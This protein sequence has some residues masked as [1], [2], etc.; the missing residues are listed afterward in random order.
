MRSF[1][2]F[3][4]GLGILALVL[5]VASGPVTRANLWSWQYG[6]RAYS[7]AAY[8][9]LAAAGLGLV[10]SLLAAVPRW[11]KGAWIPVIALCA[12][13]A[14]LTPPILLFE[15]AK[16]VPPIHDITTDPF[17]PPRFVSLLAARMASPNGA[18]YG[19][20]AI[21]AQQQKGYPDIKPAIVK[22]APA[23]AM[24]RAIDA[25][26]ALGWQVAAS[27][28]ATGRLEA[29]DTTPWFGFKD[30]IVVRVRAEPSG[31]SRVDVRSASRVGRSDIGTNA[32]RVREFLSRLA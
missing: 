10:L 24:Q 8:T 23:E 16:S 18:E 28:V 7:W 25:A 6:L 27:D 12:G 15:K 1:R 9:G 30:D 5:L 17:N 4:L 31:G 32:G 3:A 13:A 14:A 11:R 19:G 26:R 2:I 20:I 21:A 22:A 29:T